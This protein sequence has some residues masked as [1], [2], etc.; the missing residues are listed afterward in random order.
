MELN[1]SGL[2][3]VLKSLQDEYLPVMYRRGMAHA[4]VMLAPCDSE[5]EAK[6]KELR[7]NLSA[8]VD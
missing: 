2:D 6:A 7:E 3:V 8:F 1:K 4:L 5:L